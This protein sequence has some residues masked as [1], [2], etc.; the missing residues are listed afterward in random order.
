MHD[1]IEELAAQ[2]HSDLR[3]IRKILHQ[4]VAAQVA[5]GGLA[6]VHKSAMGVI[7]KAEAI[8]LKDL[9][10]ELRLAHSTVS[11]LVDRLAKKGLVERKANEADLRFS[12]IVPTYEVKK[13]LRDI[14]PTLEKQPLAE[15]LKKARPVQRESISQGIATLRHLLE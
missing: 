3:A 8:S 11:G 4:P 7:V 13:F 6:D 2:I 1:R 14:R 15:A 12:K 10:Q 9:S 5:R